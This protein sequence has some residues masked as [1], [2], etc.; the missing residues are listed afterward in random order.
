MART[1]SI[2]HQPGF[3]AIAAA[4]F[5][6]LY[7]PIVVLVAYAFNGATST[8]EWGGFSLKWFQ[9][10]W[11]N[12]QVIDATLRSFQIAP[13]TM[14]SAP[15]SATM[16]PAQSRLSWASGS[17][18]LTR[19][20]TM[21]TPAKATDQVMPYMAPCREDGPVMLRPA[22]APDRRRDAL[23]AFLLVVPTAARG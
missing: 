5:V 10:A 9:S 8:S 3:T 15:V 11:Q 20:S 23:H 22:R 18:S 7:L 1:F 12:T 4:C 14:C 17:R 2:K 19:L 21:D 6:V 13:P 16:V